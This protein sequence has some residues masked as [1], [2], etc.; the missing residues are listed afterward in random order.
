MR[1]VGKPADLPFDFR[2]DR[3][4][5][6]PRTFRS[7]TARH[8]VA[9]ASPCVTVSS[10]RGCSISSRTSPSGPRKQT[11]RSSGKPG[12]IAIATGA[13][14]VSMPEARQFGDGGVEIGDDERARATCPA[15]SRREEDGSHAGGVGN[16]RASRARS[17]PP[18]AGQHDLVHRD[19]AVD[20]QVRAVG[21]L[22]RV[23]PRPRGSRGADRRRGRRSRSAH[24]IATNATSGR[25]PSISSTA[26]PSGILDEHQP[27][28]RRRRRARARTAR[29]TTLPPS[30]AT[31]ADGRVEVGDAEPEALEPGL[32]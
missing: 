7:G 25:P 19:R 14:I 4:R 9:V 17:P 27:D 11:K 20:A 29:S 10:A 28:R 32:R 22:A 8:Y 16:P 21:V 18:G 24:V 31:R 3:A 1:H 30:A 23:A 6:C 13:E 5:P 26:V 12:P 15:C 2:Q